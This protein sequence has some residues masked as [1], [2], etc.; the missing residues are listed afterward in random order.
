MFPE[1]TVRINDNA[2]P[3]LI[4]VDEKEIIVSS[5]NLT[6]TGLWVNYEAGIWAKDEVMAK[7][8]YAFFERLWDAEE[9]L[10]LS[11]ETLDPAKA[12]K[13]IKAKKSG[14]SRR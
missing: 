3:K 10:V 9:T 11:E 14:E 2:H 5:A 7:E 1:D 13:I 12:R 8:G 6:Q 4:I